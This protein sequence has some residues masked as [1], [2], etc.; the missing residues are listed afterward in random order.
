MTTNL[1]KGYCL[2]WIHLQKGHAAEFAVKAA[3]NRVAYRLSGTGARVNI[4]LPTIDIDLVDGLL[5]LESPAGWTILIEF[6]VKSS[7]SPSLHLGGEE[8]GGLRQWIAR[9]AGHKTPALLFLQSWHSRSLGFYSPRD[10]REA[11]AAA[12]RRSLRM[13]T[14]TGAD[15]VE[16]RLGDFLAMVAKCETEMEAREAFL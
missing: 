5:R 8:Y 15:D 2:R 3:I 14:T 9:S 7:Q 1:P 16:T 6:S 4:Y 13:P 12:G 10:I 11:T